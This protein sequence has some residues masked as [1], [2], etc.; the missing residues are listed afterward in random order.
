MALRILFTSYWPKRS[1]ANSYR[2]IVRQAA[3]EVKGS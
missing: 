1:F 3:V 2:L